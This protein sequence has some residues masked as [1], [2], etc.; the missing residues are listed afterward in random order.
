M[1]KP[2]LVGITGG[3]GSGKSIVSKFFHVLGVPI[4]NSD[5]RGKYLM[6]EDDQL[7]EQVKSAFGSQSYFE[8]G[9]LNRS[10]L[11][12]EVF[13]NQE[14]LQTLNDL[15]HPAV[16]RDFENWVNLNF[17]HPYLMKEA[18]LLFETGIYKQLDKV[19]C[20]MAPEEVRL[21]RVLLRDTQRS[22][23]QI[24]D[25]MNRQVS[26]SKRKKLSDSLINNDGTELL[27]PQV[28]KLHQ[29]FLNLSV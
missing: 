1:S 6:T 4:Y 19:I 7:V 27:I 9:S 23:E 10:Y 21:D 25:I 22:L 13:P 8:D 3:I 16:G 20:V 17:D 24:E 15:V 2:L 12:A 29:D 14:K 11:A 18:A 26:D 28:L 5:D